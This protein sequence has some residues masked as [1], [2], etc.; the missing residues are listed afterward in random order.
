MGIDF[1]VFAFLKYSRLQD[2]A[3]N[4]TLTLGRQS[5]NF[6][7]VGFEEGAYSD[8]M[9]VALFEST[10][11][12]AIDNSKYEGANLNFDMNLP[13]PSHLGE[14]Y[15]TIVDAGCLEHIFDVTQALKNISSLCKRGG[16]II[17]VLPSNNFCGHGFYQFSPEL[18]FSLYSEENGYGET[19]V[20]IAD[21]NCE[22]YWYRAIPPEPG[23]RI[24]IMSETPLY[25]LVKTKK[26]SNLSDLNVQQSDYMY[27]WKNGELGNSSSK[28][29]IK[30]KLRD[31]LKRISADR[32]TRM[33][34]NVI[35]PSWK[36]RLTK[37]NP[38]FQR[39]RITK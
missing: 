18:F 33:V 10:K 23:H 4:D 20:F 34:C 14:M 24:E 38:S 16:H 35:F 8:K 13:L 27:M 37:Y 12:D 30:K 2:G 36:L 6:N 11:V 7:V 31:K 9:F 19:E 17:H 29:V 15:D 5:I 3:F 25:V 39:E 28:V 26:I 22:K 32:I 1:H 21:L